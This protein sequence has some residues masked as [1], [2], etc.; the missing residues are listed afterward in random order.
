[1]DRIRLP[2]SVSAAAG[3]RQRRSVS[4]VSSIVPARAGERVW[5]L[6][7]DAGRPLVRLPGAVPMEAMVCRPLNSRPGLPGDSHERLRASHARLHEC[8]YPSGLVVNFFV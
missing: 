8:L 3:Y 5:A 2:L 7:P 6:R 1:M 4:V